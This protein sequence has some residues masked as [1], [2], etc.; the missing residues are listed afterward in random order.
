MRKSLLLMLLTVSTAFVS[1]QN[2]D[3]QRWANRVDKSEKSESITSK[4]K[5]VIKEAGFYLEKSSKYQYAAIGCAGVGM[6][7]AI[8]S[9]FIG[10]KDSSKAEDPQKEAKSDRNLQKGLL[11]GAGACAVAAVCCEL[12]SIN[13]KMKAGR[14]LRLYSTGTGGG[15]AYTF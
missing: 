8:G 13:Y 11:I 15:L 4:Q 3:L 9:S 12:A 6:G 2:A 14:S 1:A 7:L 5:N 10:T